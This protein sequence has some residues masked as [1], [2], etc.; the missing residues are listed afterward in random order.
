MGA[1]PAAARGDQ[2]CSGG[3]RDWG[4]GDQ[5][6]VDPMF[7]TKKVPSLATVPE[8]SSLPRRFSPRPYPRA[9]FLAPPSLHRG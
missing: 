1:L 8:K 7:K 6:K 5:D 4:F 3:K 2:L 9:F